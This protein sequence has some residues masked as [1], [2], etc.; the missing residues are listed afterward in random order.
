[1]NYYN[2]YHIDEVTPFGVASSNNFRFFDEEGYLLNCTE[3]KSQYVM[4]KDTLYHSEELFPEPE[5]KKGQ[6]EL[7]RLEK[8]SKEEYFAFIKVQEVQELAK[9]ESF[10]K[11]VKE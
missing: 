6:Y 1:M 5:D 10:L 3:E 11:S 2:I 8:I 7:V 9:I 4:I